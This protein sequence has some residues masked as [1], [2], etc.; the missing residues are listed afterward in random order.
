MYY[1]WD[2]PK[3][4][5]CFW[6]IDAGTF[7]KV[8]LMSEL[9]TTE[10][11]EICPEWSGCFKC[12][13]CKL[14]D[15]TLLYLQCESWCFEWNQITNQWVCSIA[16]VF[17]IAVAL[18]HKLLNSA[19]TLRRE[20]ALQSVRTAQQDL[21]RYLIILR[22]FWV[23]TWINRWWRRSIRN[24]GT[25]TLIGGRPN[26]TATDWMDSSCKK[27]ITE[28]QE[29]CTSQDGSTFH[30]ECFTCDECQQ[31]IAGKPFGMDAAGNRVCQDCIAKYQKWCGCR[32]GLSVM[33]CS[34]VVV[35]V[36]FCDFWMQRRSF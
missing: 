29:G 13:S 33:A 10:T 16:K 20:G 6:M 11:M 28:N 18:I 17:R 4:T 22:S 24:A 5:P 25:F 27:D 34:S 31:S 15:W 30:A 2:C 1:I 7:I 3:L 8:R 21:M 26:I 23:T 36:C 12:V 32:G 14:R 19:T 9:Q 35:A